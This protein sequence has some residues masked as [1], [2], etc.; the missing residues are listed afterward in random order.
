MAVLATWT[1]RCCPPFCAS[2]RVHIDHALSLIHA[3]GKRRI[4]LLGLSFKEGTDD[5]R[6]SP[7]VTVAERLIGKGYELLIFDRNVKVASLVGANRDYILNHIPHISRLLVDEPATLFERSDLIVVATG[8]KEFGELVRS[9]GEDKPVVDL[10]GAWDLG[11]GA[12]AIHAPSS[13]EG[14]AW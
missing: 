7:I 11:A 13:Y 12:D 5:L 4:G 8:E 9:H 1:R 14:I 3:S 2:N 10:V 6:E